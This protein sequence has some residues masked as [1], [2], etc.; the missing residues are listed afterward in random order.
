MTQQVNKTQ[1]S[2]D[3]AARAKE[4]MTDLYRGLR[5]RLVAKEKR[6]LETPCTQLEREVLVCRERLM[7]V[8]DCIGILDRETEKTDIDEFKLLGGAS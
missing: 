6:L 1:P 5:L 2:V 3:P 7:Q 4:K 8:K